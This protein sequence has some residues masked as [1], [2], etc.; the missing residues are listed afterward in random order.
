MF[1]V[2]S[3]AYMDAATLLTASAQSMTFGSNL[4]IQTSKFSCNF[5]SSSFV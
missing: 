1:N 5:F 4:K 3:F 2:T